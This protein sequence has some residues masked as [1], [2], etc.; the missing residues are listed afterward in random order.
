MDIWMATEEAYKNGYAKGVEDGRREIMNAITRCINCT[1]SESA[2]CPKGKVW[3]NSIGRYMWEDDFC[4]YGENKYDD[5][6]E[7]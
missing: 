7:K 2:F 1:M 3:C 5:C 4:S 6:M